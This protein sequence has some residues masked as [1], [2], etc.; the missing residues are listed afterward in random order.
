MEKIQT[1]VIQVEKSEF[2]K[3]KTGQRFKADIITNTGKDRFIRQ[4]DLDRALKDVVHQNDLDKALK[5]VIRQSDLDKAINGIVQL[6]K[7]IYDKLRIK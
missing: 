3:C 7:P 2:D 5:G 1:K 4:S 6:M